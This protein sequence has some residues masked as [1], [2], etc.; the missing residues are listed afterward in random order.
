MNIIIA[1]CGKVGANLARKLA[2]EGYDLT[3]IDSNQAVLE[4]S[5][6]RYDVITVQGNCAS[7]QVLLQAG[8]LDADLLI[9][10]TG[11]DEINL[12]SCTTA[13][14]LN[15]KLHTIARIRNPD[16]TDQ[17]YEMRDT[18]ALSLAVN[19]EKQAA[20]EIEGLLKFPGFLHRDTFA[21][22]R[23]EIVELRVNASSVLCNQPLVEMPNLVKCRV[24][25]CAVLRSG[26][27]VVPNTGDFVLRE[28][29]R[30]FVTAPTEN[31]TILLKNLGIITR[32]VRRAILCGGGR[33]SYYLAS[34]LERDNVDVELIEQKESRCTELAALLPKCCVVCGDATDQGLLESEGL[35]DCDALVSVTGLDELNMIISLYGNSRRV[36]QVI[37]KLSRMSN[38]SIA[39]TLSLGSVVCPK[40]LCCNTIVRYVRAMQN[41]SGAAISVHA[42]ADGQVEAIEFLVEDDNPYCNIPLKK[43]TPKSNVLIASI[44]HGASAEIPNGESVFRG[45]DTVVVVSSGNGVIRQFGD[46]FE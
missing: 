42:I 7:K 11:A 14:G 20:E 29:D 32:R 18:F 19:P 12:L 34:L 17:I 44:A 23:S 6:E 27:A 41:Q 35:A 37:T 30:L 1:G 2:A 31:L 10:V 26:T 9:A 16:Y 39:D 38:R 21:K 25:V 28:G 13:H 8:V 43:L 40:E 3:M 46:L 24:L 15:P 4:S 45:G 33:V 36:P 22:G 5:M